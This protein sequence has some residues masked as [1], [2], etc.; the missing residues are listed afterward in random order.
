MNRI[1]ALLGVT[2]TVMYLCFL[3]F[4]I[5]G[6]VGGLATLELNAVGDFFAGVF[7]PVAILWLVLGFFQQGY[8]LR[9][10]NQALALQAAELKNS[11]EQQKDL[12]EVTRAQLQMEF[13]AI[14]A[15][16]ERR[17][18]EIRPFFVA[19]GGGGSH[20]GTDHELSFSIRNLGHKVTRVEFKFSEEFKALERKLYVLDS[21]EAAEFSIA[22]SGSG[23]GIASWA[24]I[25]YIDADYNTHAAVF[26]FSVEPVSYARPHPR[27]KVMLKGDG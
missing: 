13:D 12:V 7:G 1:L 26:E 20:S 23:E 6:R 27:L 11:V 15:S 5:G 2:L 17:A 21:G 14:R 10:N 24:K 18:N 4:L 16:S 19:E 8:E 25:V 3:W 22:F 9:Q